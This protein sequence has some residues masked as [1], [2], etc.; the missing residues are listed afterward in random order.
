MIKR[1]K[2]NTKMDK[3][4]FAARLLA[5]AAVLTVLSATMPGNIAIAQNLALEEIVVTAERRIGN[6]QTTPVAVTAFTAGRR[7]P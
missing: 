4:P 6:L 3:A 5:S 2:T 7:N 1:A